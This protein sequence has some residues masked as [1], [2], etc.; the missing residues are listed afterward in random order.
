[1][2]IPKGFTLLE[3]MI[4]TAIVAILAAIAVPAYDSYI[5]KTRRA[6][7]AGCLMELSAFMER[8]Y[9][10]NLTYTGATLP[11]TQCQNDLDSYYTFGLDS[12]KLAQRT[13]TLQ[14]V[15]AGSQTTDACG[16][17]GINQAGTKTYKSGA[18]SCW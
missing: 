11:T 14:A 16:T 17:L 13:Y 7:A 15:P 12:T 6:A 10:T 5:I 3:L 1:M 2:N 8:H 9:T 18:T 4:V